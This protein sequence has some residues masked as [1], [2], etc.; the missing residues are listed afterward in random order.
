M[1]I[2]SNYRAVVGTR[3]RREVVMA[4]TGGQLLVQLS[5]MPVTLALPSIA[6]NFDASIED[7][8][9]IVIVNLLVLGST[10]F[11]GARLGDR[12]GHPKMFFIGAI[13]ITVAAVFISA[14]QN[15]E[16]VII[17]RGLQGLGAGPMLSR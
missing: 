5:S 14:A 17:F 2:L 13:I 12:Y 15:L 7:A 11:L 9:W 6:R 10:V 4:M 3:A 16:Q 1:G 8:A